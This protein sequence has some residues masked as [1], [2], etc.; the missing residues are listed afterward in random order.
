[1]VGKAAVFAGIRPRCGAKRARK[2]LPAGVPRV[3]QRSSRLREGSAA[4][5]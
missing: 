4:Q 2:D 5:T 1:M 3:L